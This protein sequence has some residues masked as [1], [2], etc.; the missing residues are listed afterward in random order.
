MGVVEG[1][2]SAD[3]SN[4]TRT[5]SEVRIPPRCLCVTAYGNRTPARVGLCGEAIRDVLQPCEDFFATNDRVCVDREPPFSFLLPFGLRRMFRIS[6]L[7]ASTAKQLAVTIPSDHLEQLSTFSFVLR[8]DTVL[9]GSSEAT[10]EVYKSS[11]GLL[12]SKVCTKETV[13]T[14]GA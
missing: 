11:V 12:V 10:V 9:G 4:V 14:G 13:L 7:Q 8:V 2:L 6:A 1:N 5:L 3:V